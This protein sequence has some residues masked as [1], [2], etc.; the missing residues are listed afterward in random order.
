MTP[1]YVALDESVFFFPF[2]CFNFYCHYVII[3]QLGDD[4]WSPY[5]IC[6]Y[7]VDQNGSVE[8]TFHPYSSKIS[9]RLTLSLTTS[10]NRLR[11]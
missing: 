9:I 11:S 1:N 10:L 8:G 2:Y 6:E 4:M 5:T 3:K 7:T